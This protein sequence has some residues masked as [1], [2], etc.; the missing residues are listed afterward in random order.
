MSLRRGTSGGGGGARWGGGAA[1][2]RP[3]PLLVLRG[4]LLAQRREVGG[5]KGPA[6]RDGTGRGCPTGCGVGVPKEPRLGRRAG[7]R[8]SFSGSPAQ[9]AGAARLSHCGAGRGRRGRIF[10]GVSIFAPLSWEDGAGAPGNVAG[11]LGSVL[12][13]MLLRSGC[14][15]IRERASAARGSGY[16]SGP[17]PPAARGS[18]SHTLFP[19]PP[20]RGQPTCR[21][22]VSS[23]PFRPCPC[24]GPSVDRRSVSPTYLS[25]R[26]APAPARLPQPGWRRCFYRRA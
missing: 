24:I 21:L 4:Q 12:C 9:P 26:V 13:S 14:V 16:A 19:I 25:G 10:W 22:P 6:R 7:G 15:F 23:L 2:P 3:R 18:S 20:L 1:R 5:A 17:A 11:T 8:L